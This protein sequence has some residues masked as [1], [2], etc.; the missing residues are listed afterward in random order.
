MSYKLEAS[1]GGGKGVSFS[2]LGK[3]DGYHKKRQ[4]CERKNRF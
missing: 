3:A 4:G 1:N 2:K